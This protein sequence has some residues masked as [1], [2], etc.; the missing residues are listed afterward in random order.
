MS[1]LRESVLKCHIISVRVWRRW[2]VREWRANIG[3]VPLPRVF[4]FWWVWMWLLVALCTRW[5]IKA[6]TNI[7]VRENST[8]ASRCSTEK[9]KQMK[10]SLEKTPE[11]PPVFQ[12]KRRVFGED[13]RW[14]AVW[15]V[16]QEMVFAS[17]ITRCRDSR[18]CKFSDDVIT[19]GLGS[20]VQMLGLKNC[21]SDRSI[22][23][24]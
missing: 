13:P 5:M 24:E 7:E 9:E 2:H 3:I 22:A 23:C 1:P 16:R 10:F 21:P 8:A 6:I 11:P 20:D 14:M 17:I 12:R 18:G 15:A 4:V 19:A